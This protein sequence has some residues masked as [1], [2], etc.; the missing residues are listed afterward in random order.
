MRIR[1]RSF[2]ILVTVLVLFLA[3]L[4]FITQFL[5]LGSFQSLEDREM[6]ANVQRVVA[7]LDDQKQSLS[8]TCQDWAGRDDIAAPIDSRDPGNTQK[9]QTADL[10]PGSADIDYLVAYNAEGKLVFFEDINHPDNETLP[11]S[12]TLDR[13][14][15]ESILPEGMPLGVSGRGGISDMDGTPVLLTGCMIRGSNTSEPVKGTLVVA[16]KITDER[17]NQL[18]NNLQIPSITFSRYDGN[19]SALVTDDHGITDMK[20]GRILTRP[21]GRTEMQGVAMVTGIENKPTFILLKVT[22]DRPVYQ[23]VQASILIVAFAII[24]LGT[25]IILSVQFLLQRFALDPLDR[26]NRNVKEIGTSGELSGRV[27]VSGDEE[28]VSLARSLNR[29]LDVIEH[30]RD[31]LATARQDLASRNRELEELNR[32]ANLYLDIYLDVLTYE[33]LNANMGLAG[34]AEYLKDTARGNERVLLERISE[35]A[36]KSSSVIRNVETISRIYKTPPEVVPVNLLA[37]IKKEADARPGTRIVI[38]GCDTDVMA[39]DM[40][41]VVFDNLFSNSLKFGGSGVAIAVSA[42]N[43]G[44][45]MLEVSVEDNGPGID[46]AAKP[47]V[48]D[49][50]VRGSTVRSSYGLGL[51][52]VKMLI[53]SYGGTVRADDRVAGNPAQGVAIRFT[54]R[55]APA[56]PDRSPES[57]GSA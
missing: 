5:I 18:E 51:S 29:M 25:L 8:L 31:K 20:K 34:Y 43:T 39:N 49:R 52:I 46:D 21:S 27:P 16:R 7:N 40:L 9:V 6:T 10:A 28:V 44:S 48:F 55:L 1:T 42:Q 53:E 54:L 37:I 30:Q 33:I 36:R 57:P 35:L 22:T 41:G 50:F 11:A 3:V 19:A 23:Q 17:I 4:G 24:I 12:V 13:I 56:V 14:I 15:K 26:L 32:K 47:L 45:G 2:V 38:S